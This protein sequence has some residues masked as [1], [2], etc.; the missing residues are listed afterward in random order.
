MCVCVCERTSRKLVALA[1]N[2]VTL[3]GLA[4]A[5]RRPNASRGSNAVNHPRSAAWL[6]G[7]GNLSPPGSHE[8][9]LL[10]TGPEEHEEELQT[11]MK[12]LEKMLKDLTSV[13]KKS[14]FSVFIF[15]AR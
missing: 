12:I 3:S 1:L 4:A 14:G 5:E 7:L 9:G 2:W 6:M 10:S 15:S 11:W 13:R 8:R